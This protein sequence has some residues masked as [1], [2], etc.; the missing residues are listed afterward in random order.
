M[1]A[2]TKVTASTTRPK[3]AKFVPFTEQSLQKIADSIAADNI[4]RQKTNEAEE[5]SRGKTGNKSAGACT[6]G[7]RKDKPNTAFVA[8]KQFPDM[9]GVFPPELYGK[10]IEDLDKFYSNK[11]VSKFN[12]TF[13]DN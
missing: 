7:N 6:T 5:R 1:V 10:P 2:R 13:N 3:V 4:Q 9:F 12:L 11:Y 8:G